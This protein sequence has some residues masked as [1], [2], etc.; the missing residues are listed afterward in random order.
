MTGDSGDSGMYGAD[1]AAM[2]PYRGVV[3]RRVKAKLDA[4]HVPL[5]WLRAA[6]A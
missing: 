4:I 1:V 3:M 2:L 6:A 5:V